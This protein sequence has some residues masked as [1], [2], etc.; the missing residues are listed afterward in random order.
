M[1]TIFIFQPDS[2]AAVRQ[3]SL[4][5]LALSIVTMTGAGPALAKEYSIGIREEAKLVPAKIIESPS[6]QIPSHK[7]EESFRTSCEARFLIDPSGKTDVT[8]LTSSGS[9]EMDEIA[10]TTLRK[11]KFRPA[12]LENKPVASSRRIKIEFEVE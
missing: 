12:T 11:W 1:K 10:V 9:E 2:K 4:C 3:L 8:L 5:L 7:Q 6:P